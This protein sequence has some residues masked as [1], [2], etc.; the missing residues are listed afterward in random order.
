MDLMRAV[1]GMTVKEQISAATALQIWKLAHYG[2]PGRIRQTLQLN[3]DFTWTLEE[4]RLQMT[5][6][7]YKCRGTP[8][9]NQYP[10]DIRQEKSVGKFKRLM[11]RYILDQRERPPD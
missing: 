11:K 8:D 10:P 1:V 6:A 3:D 9:W 4:P 7:C 5:A 2:K